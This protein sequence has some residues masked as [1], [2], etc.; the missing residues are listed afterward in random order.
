M[1]NK[2]LSHSSMD[3][4]SFTNTCSKVIISQELCEYDVT[5]N[6]YM[7]MRVSFAVLGVL[8]KIV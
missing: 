1:V 6:G 4:L 7:R 2:T 5:G 3:H 8:Q